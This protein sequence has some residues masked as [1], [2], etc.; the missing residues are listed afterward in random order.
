[1]T[2]TEAKPAVLTMNEPKQ[3][4]QQKSNYLFF[5]IRNNK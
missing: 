5:L 4:E 3:K 2:P 1:M